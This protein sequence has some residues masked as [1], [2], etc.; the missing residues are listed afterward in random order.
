ML[1]VVAGRCVEQAWERIETMQPDLILALG[2]A[3][4]TPG[5]RVEERGVNCNDFP[6]PDNAGQM[7][8]AEPICP[9]GPAW[10]E[11]NL[12]LEPVLRA[13]RQRG[14][15]AERSASAGTYVCNHLFY[16]LLHR[17]ATLGRTH[18]TGFIHLPLVGTL[19]M[20]RLAEG[21][22]TVIQTCTAVGGR[23]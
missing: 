18:L 16:G 3:D 6:I 12:P 22:R 20:N 4:G 21:V 13:L 9:D 2:Q 7:F 19:S 8:H 11:T 1:P 17:A 15:P 5:L 10:Y 23:G 14:I